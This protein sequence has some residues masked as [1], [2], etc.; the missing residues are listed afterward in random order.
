MTT[1]TATAPLYTLPDSSPERPAALPV[2]EE[3]HVH[4]LSYGR[5]T[6][7]ELVSGA[8]AALGAG[9]PA[10]CPVCDSPMHRA[11]LVGP[12]RCSG[13]RCGAELA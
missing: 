11:T 4:R 6:L 10:A 1:A 9:A 3:A 7:D 2:P 13:A 12:A 8:W 5:L